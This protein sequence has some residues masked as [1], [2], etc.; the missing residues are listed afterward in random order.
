MAFLF[1]ISVIKVQSSGGAWDLRVADAVS[2]PLSPQGTTWRD[3]LQVIRAPEAATMRYPGY[4][5]GLTQT[6]DEY[7]MDWSPQTNY[8]R[9]LD[10]TLD[11]ATLDSREVLVNTWVRSRAEAVERDLL[12]AYL[13]VDIRAQTST[14]HRWK[15]PIRK[16]W[17]L[18]IFLETSFIS[19]RRTFFN[20]MIFLKCVHTHN[21]PESCHDNG[22]YSMHLKTIQ[23]DTFLKVRSEPV[24]KVSCMKKS[25]MIMIFPRKKILHENFMPQFVH[26]WNLSYGRS[27]RRTLL[28]GTQTG[29]RS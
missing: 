29:P 21:V 16:S 11:T 1:A 10:K 24:Q 4:W 6:S 13:V 14:Q 8:H 15:Y 22:R 19:W 25:C 23:A 17:W 28:K 20:K 5:V 9:T 12:V 7:N 3:S 2:L 27:E 18:E 26:A